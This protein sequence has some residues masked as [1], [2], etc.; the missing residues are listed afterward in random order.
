MIS[1]RHL[2]REPVLYGRCSRDIENNRH[3]R[4]TQLQLTLPFSQLFPLRPKGA[5]L[6]FFSRFSLWRKAQKLFS[7]S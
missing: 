3:T 6:W 1:R 2:A 7:S 4:N 5:R